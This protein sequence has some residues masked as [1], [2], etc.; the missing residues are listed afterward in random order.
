MRSVI[1]VLGALHAAALQTAAG[2]TLC[3]CKSPLQI[4]DTCRFGVR[5]IDSHALSTALYFGHTNPRQSITG[6]IDCLHMCR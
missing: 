3:F 4:A 1:G 5:V 2:A 6:K